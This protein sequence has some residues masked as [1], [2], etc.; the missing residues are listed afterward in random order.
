MK[1]CIGNFLAKGGQAFVYEALIVYGGHLRPCILKLFYNDL[2][3]V[4]E[5]SALTKLLGKNVAKIYGELRLGKR[6]GLL[7][8]FFPGLTLAELHE[9]WQSANSLRLNFSIQLADRLLLALDSIHNNDLVHGD[10]CP[11]NILIGPGADLRI[12]DFAHSE[13]SSSSVSSAHAFGKSAYLAPEILCGEPLSIWSDL[14]A[15][16]ALLYSFISGRK[17]LLG[18]SY[19]DVRSIINSMAPDLELLLRMLLAPNPIF[20]PRTADSARALFVKKDPEP[21]EINLERTGLKGE[22]TGHVFDFFHVSFF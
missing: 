7:M 13:A 15:V 14:F 16:G 10:L 6:L 18:Q 8:E 4:K 3:F 2:Y 21:F 12:I 20:R 22:L 1:G 5:R 17:L 9:R 19:A 11:N